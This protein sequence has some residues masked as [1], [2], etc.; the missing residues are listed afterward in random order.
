MATFNRF[1]QDGEQATTK[2]ME[3]VYALIA[4]DYK[5]AAKEINAKLK[6]LYANQLA[7]VAP[8]NYYNYLIQYNRLEKM[9]K[10]LRA[11]YMKY[12]RLAGQHVASGSEIGINNNFYRQRYN[13]YFAEVGQDLPFDVINP[14]IVN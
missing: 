7:G 11:S 2:E 4:N 13:F 6:S 12:A 9:Y 5:S 3:R 10:D 8:E 14:D 1:Q